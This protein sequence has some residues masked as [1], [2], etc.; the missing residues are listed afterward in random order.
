MTRFKHTGTTGAPFSL[1]YVQVDSRYI[2]LLETMGISVGVKTEFSGTPLDTVSDMDV[3]R[4][5]AC[6]HLEWPT[7][8]LYA[9]DSWYFD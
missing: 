5:L 1:R 7:I 4:L 8:G 3:L 6:C 2:H 9:L